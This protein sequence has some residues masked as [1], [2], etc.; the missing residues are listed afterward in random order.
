MVHITKNAVNLLIIVYLYTFL[1]C[2][3]RDKFR[4]GEVLSIAF[5][6]SSYPQNLFKRIYDH[7]FSDTKIVIYMSRSKFFDS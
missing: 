2:C 3:N 5:C 7:G 4:F 6:L 1:S